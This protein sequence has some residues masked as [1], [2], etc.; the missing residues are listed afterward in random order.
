M[1]KA[2]NLF[3][4]F[5]PPFLDGE[6]CFVPVRQGTAFRLPARSRFGEGRARRRDSHV[7]TDSHEQY[8]LLLYPLKPS[9]PFLRVCEKP[10]LIPKKPFFRNG[11]GI[12]MIC[13]QFVKT[14]N[15]LIILLITYYLIILP[16]SSHHFAFG[17]TDHP[18]LSVRK[19][20]VVFPSVS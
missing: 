19:G 9:P 10:I 11:V 12:I 13:V 4:S 14:K 15:N 2:I 5:P 6:S 3:I 20:G 16:I 8:S 17:L 1:L 7:K 18:S